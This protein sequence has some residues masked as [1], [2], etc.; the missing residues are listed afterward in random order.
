MPKK[1]ANPRA[2]DWFLTINNPSDDEL[3]DFDNMTPAPRYVIYQKEQGESGTIH[4]QLY[5]EYI[6]PTVF[7]TVKKHFPRANIRIRKGTRQDCRKYC[8]KEETRIDG[9]YEWGKW[10]PA[11]QGNRSDLDSLR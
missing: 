1:Q 11:G 8:S 9:P 10:Y 3:P 7:N 2:R 6:N 4:F 5:I